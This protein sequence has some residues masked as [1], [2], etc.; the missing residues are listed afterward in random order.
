MQLGY[1]KIF[2]YLILIYLILII[3]PK[4]N[5]NF[6]TPADEPSYGNINHKADGIFYC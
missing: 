5:A 2:E 4:I 6:T 3:S 1:L